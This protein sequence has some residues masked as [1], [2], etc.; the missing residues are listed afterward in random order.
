MDEMVS[1]K[2]SRCKNVF[3]IDKSLYE[4]RKSHKSKILCFECLQRS[5]ENKYKKASETHKKNWA[6]YNE[7]D[8][9]I[10]VI[11]AKNGI[12]NMS[13]AAKKQRSINSSI[14]TKKVM[15]SLTEEQRKSRSLK[16]SKSGKH[17]YSIMS[18]IDKR[19]LGRKI[20]EGQSHI[21]DDKKAIINKQRSESMKSYIK[22]LSFEELEMRRHRVQEWWDNMTPEEYHKWWQSQSSGYSN[23]LE[24][25]NII[26]NNNESEFIKHLFRYEIKYQFQFP[27]KIKHPEFDNLFPF[28]SVTGSKFINPFHKWDFKITTLSE[29]ILVDVDGSIHNQPSYVVT[30]PQT[31]VTYNMLDYYKFRDSQRF[32]QTDGLSAYVIQCYDD[33]LN[34]DTLVLHLNS[35]QIM[36]FKQ[37]MMNLVWLNLSS[38]DKKKIA[39][40][41]DYKF[42]D[43]YNLNQYS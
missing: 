43:I 27:N 34:D 11:N 35:N 40:I 10:R 14:A 37:F 2:C 33:K 24:S 5:K 29:E 9:L 12:H 26:P 32:Y 31:K 8:R 16:L 23:Y 6:S 17:R 21:P 7:Q 13:E 22:S 36:T 38:K 1:T 4:H 19:E 20:S 25:L 28:N 39:N 3:M 18:D 42:P 30:H 41:N 15:N